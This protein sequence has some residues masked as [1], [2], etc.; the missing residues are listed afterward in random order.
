MRRGLKPPG[1]G[2]L[3][4]TALATGAGAGAGVS[5]DDGGVGVSSGSGTKSDLIESVEEFVAMRSK[6]AADGQKKGGGEGRGEEGA[7]GGK[8]GDG[9]GVISS[10]NSSSG[11]DEDHKLTH[12]GRNH[13][14]ASK[15]VQMLN[16]VRVSE[17]VRG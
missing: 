17:G 7:K 10:S 8:E 11:N 3:A 9:S 4:P 1:Y 15:K 6:M 2:K 16:L 12:E 14:L 13:S 5:K